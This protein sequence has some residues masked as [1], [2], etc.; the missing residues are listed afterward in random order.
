MNRIWGHVVDTLYESWAIARAISRSSSRRSSFL[1]HP[2]GL[3]YV[4]HGA[5]EKQTLDR[6]FS[7]SP[8]S[9][10][11]GG[12]SRPFRPKSP[13]LLN[14]PVDEEFKAPTNRRTVRARPS[15]S[16]SAV[17]SIPDRRAVKVMVH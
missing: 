6:W 12:S 13:S 3:C 17:L 15:D 5:S 11:S 16:E 2:S 9:S 4:Y 14:R 8:I 7:T 10:S 1:V